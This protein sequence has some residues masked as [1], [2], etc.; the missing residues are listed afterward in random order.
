VGFTPG[1]KQPDGTTS[2][3]L[4]DAHA[5][6]ELYFQ[7]VGWTR[8]EPTPSRG[9]IPDYAYPDTSAPADPGDPAPEPSRSA[10]PSDGGPTAAPSCGPDAQRTGSGSACLSLPAASGAGPADGGTSP[11][12]IAGIV[13]AALLVLLLPAVPLLWRLRIRS[14]RLAATTSDEDLMAGTLAAWREL[15]DTAWDVGIL[16]DESLTPR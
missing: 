16:P 3:G 8:F 4:K 11:W 14:R 10:A 13:S 2:V 12:V 6:P 15:L 7:G 1:T 5:W 9:S